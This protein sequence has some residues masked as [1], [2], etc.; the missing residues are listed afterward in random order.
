[1]VDDGCL[2]DRGRLDGYTISS[3]C[4]PNGLGELKS[5]SLAAWL[6]CRVTTL[7]LAKADLIQHWEQSTCIGFVVRQP[8]C[9][10]STRSLIFE[11]LV[12][13]LN[14]NICL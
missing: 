9:D 11:I 3:P 6:N 2:T 13:F 14:S 7:C 10:L 8:N 5:A 12:A 1:M 4:E